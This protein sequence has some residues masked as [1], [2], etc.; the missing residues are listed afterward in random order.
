MTVRLSAAAAA[1]LACLSITLSAQLPETRVLTLDA[2]RVI[3]EGAMAQCRSEGLHVAVIVV[4]AYNAPKILL[5]DDGATAANA[6]AARM[7]ATAAM[8]YD[9]ASGPKTA[10]PAGS[11]PTPGPI[12]GT[13]ISRGAV[14][15]QVAGITIGAVSVSASPSGR[16]RDVACAE[17]GIAKAVDKLR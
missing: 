5:R 8:L 11:T 9:R 12:P 6:Q 13:Y 14:P 15:I 16:D 1:T 17:A 2:A 4:D 10:P 7:K 3:A